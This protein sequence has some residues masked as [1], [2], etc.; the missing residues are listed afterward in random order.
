MRAFR[1]WLIVSSTAVRETRRKSRVL[2]HERELWYMLWIYIVLPR[3]AVW[4]KQ[5]RGVRPG[6]SGVRDMMRRGGS[7][8]GGVGVG[9]AGGGGRGSRFQKM[10]ARV[11][12]QLCIYSSDARARSG[13]CVYVR[14]WTRSPSSRLRGKHQTAGLSEMA[15]VMASVLQLS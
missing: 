1:F 11:I 5:N 4:L 9:S 15:D 12:F 14:C 3:R 2:A 7:E 6:C 13:E 10:P 8:D